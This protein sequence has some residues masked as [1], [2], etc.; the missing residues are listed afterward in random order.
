MKDDAIAHLSNQLVSV[1]SRLLEIEAKTG[2]W[3]A[4]RLQCE[5]IIDLKCTMTTRSIMT[6]IKMGYCPRKDATTWLIF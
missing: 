4:L 5:D 2:C 1:S 6:I 3:H